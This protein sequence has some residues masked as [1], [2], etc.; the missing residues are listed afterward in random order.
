MNKGIKV[1]LPVVLFV[2]AG[3]N[4]ATPG[5]YIGAGAGYSE[6]QSAEGAEKVD[7][8]GLGGRA[9]LGYNFNHY[10]GVETNYST[11]YKTRYTLNEYQNVAV[12]YKLNALSLVVK[13][14]LPISTSG[15]F[16]LYGLAGLAQVYGDIDARV[17]YMSILQDSDNGI[18]P[19]LGLGASYDINQRITAHLEVS[20]FGS[21][22]PDN[23]HFG[24]PQSSLATF[25]LAYKF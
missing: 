13:G 10:F 21:K 16:N 12:D 17:D 25:G 20:G 2:S 18:V 24:I 23:N 4:A 9:F 5:A 22:E 7:E 11:I 6:L 3:L 14:Y 15:A 19:T 1:L 8:G